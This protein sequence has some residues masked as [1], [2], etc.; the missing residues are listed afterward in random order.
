VAKRGHGKRGDYKYFYG[1]RNEN[2]Q[3][4]TGFFVHHIMVPAVKRVEFVSDR[5][6]YVVLRGRW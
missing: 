1:K 6:S 4:G 3:F 2:H 5:L